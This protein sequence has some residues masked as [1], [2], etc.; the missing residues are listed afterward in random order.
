MQL[1][2]GFRQV[3]L[4]E[5]STFAAIEIDTPACTALVAMQ[6][7]QVL[8]MQPARQSPLLWCS[9][10]A[11][12]VPGKSVRGGIPLCFPWFGAHPENPAFPAHG[13]A[14][15]RTWRLLSA[16]R[17]SSHSDGEVGELVF[18][19]TDDDVTRTLW[20][21]PFVARMTYRFSGVLDAAF[22]VENTG[23]ESLAFGFALHSYFPVSDIDAVRVEGLEGIPFTDKL[24]PESRLVTESDAVRIG[25]EI[26]RVYVNAPGHY[27]LVDE[28]AA[29][30][31]GIRAENCRS[32]VVW[33]PWQEKA[34][35]LGDVPGDAWRHMLCVECGNVGAQ[36]VVLRAGDVAEFRQRVGWLT[37]SSSQKF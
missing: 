36:D 28:I 8:R 13:F 4:G 37:Q 11:V 29:T 15:T 21:H 34:A 5:A 30:R 24:V 6:G 2:A 35:R 18:E 9:P 3:F 10:G 17:E 25:A 16:T 23:R 1:P 19:L 22:S 32:A 12:F 26:D 14:R 31:L 33:N 7:A 27:R 20:P